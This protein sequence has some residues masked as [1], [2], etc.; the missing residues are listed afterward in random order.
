MIAFFLLSVFAPTTMFI[1]LTIVFFPNF[2]KVINFTM[3]NTLKHYVH[4][5][6]R[7][8]R[9]GKVGRSVSLVG[10]SERKMLKEIVR[11]AK[12]PVKARVIPQGKSNPWPTSKPTPKAF[13]SWYY[14]LID[15]LKIKAFKFFGKKKNTYN[16]KQYLECLDCFA[17]LFVSEV[18]LKFRDLIEKLEKDIY[19][20][21][22]LERE[23]KEMVHS[24][25]QVMYKILFLMTFQCF[26]SIF[27]WLNCICVLVLLD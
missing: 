12:A 18:I 20:V 14:W 22:R 19:A 13:K 16:L 25:A 17:C 21:L 11:K 8:A 24:E 1:T 2:L 27:S 6:G 23:E 9:A 15:R 5:V 7:T 26:V 3:P 4:R 10:E